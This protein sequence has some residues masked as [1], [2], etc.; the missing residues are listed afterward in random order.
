MK[1]TPLFSLFFVILCSVLFSCSRASEEKTSA[2]KPQGPISVEQSEFAPSLKNPQES[3]GSANKTAATPQAQREQAEE[4][5]APASPQETA[6]QT[7]PAPQEKA[8]PSELEQ[9]P[10]ATL[11]P[12]KKMADPKEIGSISAPRLD[13]DTTQEITA[14]VEVPSTPILLEAKTHLAILIDA[15]GSMVAPFTSSSSSKLEL[16][17]ASLLSVLSEVEAEQN[18]FPRNIAIS[19]F[20][21]KS[22]A[23]ENNCKDFGT[24]LPLGK[25]DTSV[26]QQSLLS[27]KPQGISPISHA[28]EETLKTFPSDGVDKVIVLI[29]D[30][31]DTCNQNIC[32]SVAEFKEKY[33]NLQIN[34]VGFDLSTDDQKQLECIASKADGSFSLVRN[35]SELISSLDQAINFNVPYNLKISVKAG[36]TALPGKITVFKAGSEVPLREETSFGTKLL[37][38]NPGT[39]DLLIEYSQSSEA[40][41]PSKLIKGVEVLA[42]SKIEQMINFDL[43]PITLSAV[44]DDDKPVAARYEF[45]KSGQKSPVAQITAPAQS[46]TYFLTPGNYNI[47]AMKQDSGPEH[48]LLSEE[49]V[50]LALMNP[51]EKVF[52]FQRGSIALKNITSQQ[53]SLPFLFRIYDQEK[54]DHLIGSGA[55]PAEGGSIQV[56]PGKYSLLLI[57]QDP[58]LPANPRTRI[59]NV[60]VEPAKTVEVNAL[61][62]MAILQLHAQNTQNENL[63]ASF[64]LYEKDSGELLTSVDYN[65]KE[66]TTIA[67]PPGNYDILSTLTG[68][69]LEPKPSV[70]LKNVT[71]SVEQPANV[72]ALFTLGTLRLRG[73]TSKGKTV[74]TKFFLFNST[75]TEAVLETPASE[76]WVTLALVPGTYDVKAVDFNAKED[77]TNEKRHV[78]LRDVNVEDAKSISHEAIFTAGKL[79]IIGRGPNGKLINCTFKVFQYGADRELI[80]GETG[81]DWKTFEIDPGRYYLEAAYVDKE[82]SVVLKKWINLKIDDNE[83]VENV[84]RF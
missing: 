4:T 52:R 20:G 56:A 61:F 78:W 23:D 46:K 35:E 22:S 54:P 27:L 67:I 79:R 84:L 48:F 44:S 6:E 32:E 73:E 11:E 43:A 47:V 14:P 5:P 49:N 83:I 81:D 58:K 62:Q 40:K 2:E 26:L 71:V 1:K 9:T 42:N 69:F 36:E 66:T 57:G 50:S 76:A 13:I 39:Y 60:L 38:L 30:G 19:S 24:L 21:N 80:N 10:V 25:I 8:E 51:V 7:P 68:D 15:S 45:F 18:D 12:E 64:K 17:N 37:E 74:T 33:G 28:L 31:A 82:N 34:V 63:K 70:R 16:L 55:L 75:E 72:K 3:K 53:T 29:A 41:L 59:T 65:G 77:D